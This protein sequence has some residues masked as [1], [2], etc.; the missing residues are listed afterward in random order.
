MAHR[1]N[2]EKEADMIAEM[3]RLIAEDKARVTD[4]ETAN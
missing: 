2:K 1:T 4:E 3:D